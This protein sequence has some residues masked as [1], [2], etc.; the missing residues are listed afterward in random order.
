MQTEMRQH[1]TVASG[2]IF[3][4]V[5]ITDLW[6]GRGHDFDCKVEAAND[7]KAATVS[8]L[9]CQ[10]RGTCAACRPA[11]GRTPRRCPEAV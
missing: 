6:G 7:T 1:G 3:F 9:R 11:T 8:R 5:T 2:G 4:P 10:Q